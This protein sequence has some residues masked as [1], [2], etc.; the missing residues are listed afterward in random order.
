MQELS[1]RLIPRL[2]MLN[3]GIKQH[4]DQQ[5]L[6]LDLTA[7]QSFVLHYL[8][9]HEA[10]PIYPKDLEHS[11]HLTHPT[12]SGILQ[13]L[14]AKG[15]ITIEQDHTDRRCKRIRMTQKAH[16][17]EKAVGNSF[18][19]LDQAMSTGMSTQERAELLRLL[20]LAT[21]NLRNLQNLEVSEL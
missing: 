18:R 13:R 10:E 19:Q 17:C 11:F 9:L 1:D 12:I 4:M 5:F 2:R 14:E 7:T 6:K 20:D 8:A 3:N 21:E 15:F 16:C